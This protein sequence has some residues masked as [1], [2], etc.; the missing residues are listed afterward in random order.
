[1]HDDLC[2][3]TATE[4]T[5]RMQAREL[6]AVEVMTAHLARIERLNPSVNAIVTLQPDVAME[7][8]RQADEAL[9]RGVA[10]GPLHGL[11]IA[12]KDLV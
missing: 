10:P 6:S 1:M 12:H 9:A 3:L 11:P 7:R 8:A 4:L 2:F 5:R